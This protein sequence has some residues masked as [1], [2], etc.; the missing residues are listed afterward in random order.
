[1]PRHMYRLPILVAVIALLLTAPAVWAGDRGRDRDEE[2][3]IPFD[4]AEI[5]FELNDTDGDLGIHALIDGDA[6]KSLQFKDPSGR[7]Q[8]KIRLRSKL[9]QQGLTELFF[10]SAEPIFAE[11]PPEE[12]FERFQ[13]GTYEVEGTTLEGDELESETELTHLM[14]APPQPTVNGIPM[15]EQCDEEEPGYDAPEVTAPVT[16]A[17]PAV[18][19]SHPDLGS[20]QGSAD[21]VIHNYQLVVE[22]D[23]ETADGEELEVVFSVILPPGVTSMMIPPG[24]L[25]LSDGFK[26]EVLA[27]EESFNQTARESCFLLE[28]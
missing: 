5:F 16:I 12:F 24:F 10:E 14:P 2:D 27:R 9:R 8:L 23:I 22:A 15:A 19:T 7:G 25:A 11:L 28:E 3:E 20:P 1:M 17:W 6:W 4:E 26:Y 18:A 13:E 21:I